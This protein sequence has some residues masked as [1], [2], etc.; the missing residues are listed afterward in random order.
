MPVGVRGGEH[1][2][3]VGAKG[4]PVLEG[5]LIREQLCPGQGMHRTAVALKPS[6]FGPKSQKVK[7]RARRLRIRERLSKKGWLEL[8]KA[9]AMAQTRTAKART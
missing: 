2:V 3:L 9:I 7:T 8:R 5:T 1:H 6:K 4:S